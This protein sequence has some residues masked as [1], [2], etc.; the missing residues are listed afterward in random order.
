M[1]KAITTKEL[2]EI[3]GISIKTIGR[4]VACGMPCYKGIGRNSKITYKMSEVDKWLRSN[5]RKG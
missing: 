2:A 5:V 1:E 4:Y 3:L